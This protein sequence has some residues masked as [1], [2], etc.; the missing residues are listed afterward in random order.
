LNNRK[1]KLFALMSLMMITLAPSPVWAIT[2]GVPDG[3]GHPNV[4]AMIV[5][6]HNE[7]RQICSGTL[8]AP[9][10]FLTAAHCTSIVEALGITEVW[11]TFDTEFSS[12]STLIPGTT[13]TNPGYNMA[14]SDPGDIAVITFETPI[15]GIIPASLPTAGLFDQMSVRNG[16]H[17]QEFTAVGYGLQEPTYGGG[18]PV[19]GTSGTRMVATSTFKAINPAW[20]RLSQNPATSD[21]GTCFGDSGG[22]NFL[23]NSDQIAGITITG[24]SMCQ[25]TNVIYRLDTPA[26][27]TFLTNYVTLP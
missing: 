21:G 14:Q 9:T 16:L 5:D 12:T 3:S 2:Y 1:A 19:W 11:V 4:G 27:R 8:I 18:P 23:G 26:A 7:K 24:D 10:V 6:I 22:P 13:H 15:I 25:A 17:D 20:L